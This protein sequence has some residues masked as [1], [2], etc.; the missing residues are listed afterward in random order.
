MGR[1]NRNLC[2]IDIYRVTQNN[3]DHF[4]TNMAFP[5]GNRLFGGDF[6]ATLDE[7]DP[8][9]VQFTKTWNWKWIF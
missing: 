1:L 9:M 7:T 8:A 6:R 2:Y 3:D 5:E 4:K